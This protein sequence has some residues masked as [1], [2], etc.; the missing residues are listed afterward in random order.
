MR[1]LDRQQYMI[2]R[3]L[4]Y[5]VFLGHTDPVE[6]AVK[7]RDQEYFRGIVSNDLVLR[8]LYRALRK[9]FPEGV[10]DTCS[11]PAPVKDWLTGSRTRPG[12]GGEKYSQLMDWLQEG[13]AVSRRN[14]ELWKAAV[15]NA[16][17]RMAWNVA[18]F[19]RK[20]LPYTLPVNIIMQRQGDDLYCQ[21]GDDFAWGRF[22]LVFP[23]AAG[24][25]PDETCEGW[26]WWLETQYA[27]GCLET[28]FLLDTKG[29][30]ETSLTRLA[31]STGWIEVSIPCQRPVIQTDFYD[32]TSQWREQ[33]HQSMKV[34]M[35]SAAA[36]VHK[37]E[38][39]GMWSLSAGERAPYHLAKT[40]ACFSP[41]LNPLLTA[42]SPVDTRTLAQLSR[43]PSAMEEA[44]RLVDT[45]G[46]RELADA[47]RTCTASFEAGNRRSG[48]TACRTVRAI[49]GNREKSRKGR[50][51]YYHLAQVVQ[52]VATEHKACWP[53]RA[54]SAAALDAVRDVLEPAIHAKG[55]GGTFPHY[56][57]I[58]KSYGE[59]LTVFQDDT[60]NNGTE[61]SG[62]TFALAVG[63]APLTATAE[64]RHSLAGLEFTASNAWDCA[65]ERPKCRLTTIGPS[66]GGAEEMLP[67]LDVA[68]CILNSRKL[69]AFYLKEH[70]ANLKKNRV[71]RKLGAAAFLMSLLFA[72]SLWFLFTVALPYLSPGDFTIAWEPVDILVFAAGGALFGLFAGSVMFFEARRKII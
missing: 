19:F 62:I 66:G 60:K 24:C 67:F 29:G 69:P 23:D 47:I 44:C 3:M 32:Y 45:A 49:L 53:G 35:E 11:L 9:L 15:N 22:F 1:Y 4:T 13:V 26:L 50:L 38:M 7:F 68:D 56:R 2:D 30:A 43:N 57:R 64:G 8:H 72:L 25:L 28:R 20:L 12:T 61:N 6:F 52:N 51:L 33:G 18:D 58:T 65:W 10:D 55:Y 39:L 31:E 48:S 41:V 5:L 40:L 59:Y 46:D 34:F 42:R 16:A 63:R 71:L 70:R 14:L 36:L 54:Q 37:A 27:G 17:A 21:W